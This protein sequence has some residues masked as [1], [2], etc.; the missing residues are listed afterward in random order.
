MLETK[1][2]KVKLKP[3]SLPRVRSWANELNSRREEALETM[4]NESMVVESTFLDSNS[5]GDF[6]ICY[7]KAESFE[8]AMVVV[9]QSLYAI[10]AYHQTF[11]EETT[12]SA[13]QLEL[14]VDFD[15]ISEL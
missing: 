10:D 11:K 5:E 1:C 4:R 13:A 8:K 12:E 3:D 7:M 6:L 9:K 2:V 14:L 15:R